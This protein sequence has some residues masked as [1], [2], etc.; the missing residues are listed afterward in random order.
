MVGFFCCADS[1]VSAPFTGLSNG[2]LGF[3]GTYTEK[4]QEMNNQKNRLHYLDNLR[5]YLTI[6]VILHHATLPYARR[7]L[8]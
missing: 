5:I 2:Q 1:N 7:V 4:G 3:A 6:L 8:G